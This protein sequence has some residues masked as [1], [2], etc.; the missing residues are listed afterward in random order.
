M[1]LTKYNENLKYL[2]KSNSMLT[3]NLAMILSKHQVSELKKFQNFILQD[4]KLM[5]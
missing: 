4:V 1:L 3:K 5:K 2:S